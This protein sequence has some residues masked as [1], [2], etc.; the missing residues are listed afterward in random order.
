METYCVSF[1]TFCQFNLTS[2]GAAGD[3]HGIGGGFET[4]VVFGP[5]AELDLLVDTLIEDL[6][7]EI[8]DQPSGETVMVGTDLAN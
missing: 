4:F 7:I 2:N 1:N 8:V 5:G 3:A 6:T